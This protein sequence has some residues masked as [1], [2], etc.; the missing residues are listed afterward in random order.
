M[1]STSTPERASHQAVLSPVTPAP[2]TTTEAPLDAATS[3]IGRCS[4]SI[5]GQGLPERDPLA[6]DAEPGVPVLCDRRL[7]RFI[8][9]GGEGQRTHRRA[10]ARERDGAER[11]TR[12]L[13]Q[14]R[15]DLLAA[16]APLAGPHARPR[17]TF[18]L[19]LIDPPLIRERGEVARPLRRLVAAEV[20]RRPDA[21][22]VV[23]RNL[24]TL[25]DMSI[26]LGDRARGPGP[27]EAR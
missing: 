25:A 18:D 3:L 19:I 10:I 23:E 4:S 11:H 2:T 26:G 17:Q 14:R 7:L 21:E 9:E 15:P 6:L 1:T 8:G 5:G 13:R 22:K 12:R 20:T 27:E 16:A 24:L